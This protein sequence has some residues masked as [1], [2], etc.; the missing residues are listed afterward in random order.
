MLNDRDRLLESLKFSQIDSRR[1]NIKRHHAKTCQ[2]FLTH[3]DYISWLDPACLE[4]TYGFLWV[5]GKPGSG[6]S[7]IMKFA[8]SKMKSKLRP[9]D[10]NNKSVTASFFFNARGE[11]LEKSIFGMYRSLLYQLLKG[12]PELQVALDDLESQDD[13][14]SLNILKDLFHSAV[15]SL[16]QR[17]FTC[18]IDA[19]DE[20]DE[21]Q[22]REMVDYFED[23]AEECTT[24][25]IPF[26]ICF[27]SRHYPY[28]FIRRG[29]R[30]TLEDQAGH[31]KDLE[32]YITS[33]LLVKEQALVEEIYPRLLT[34]AAGV[35]M[36]V[37]LV[38]DILNK[39]YERGG[40]SLRKRLAEIPSDLSDLFK[41][42]LRRDKENMEV[43][44][45][46]IRW[47]LFA[48]RPLQPQEFYHA[49]WC[50]LAAKDLADDQ[51]PDVTSPESSKR[52]SIFVISSSKGLAEITSSNTPTV[53]FIHESV[54]D[55]LIKDRGIF[56][57]WPEL[58]AEWDDLA[59]NA[60]SDCCHRYIL[61]FGTRIPAQYINSVGL[62]SY[63]FLQYATQNVFC[64]SNSASLTVPQSK[65]LSIFPVGLWRELHN[66]F[67][68]FKIR[69]YSSTVTLLYILADNG[70]SN[71]VRTKIPDD[72][73]VE[74]QGERY[75]YPLF[76]ALAS[77]SKDTVAALLKMPSIIED[78]VDIAE[79]LGFRKDLKSYESRTPLTWA[80]QEGRLG[81]LKQLLKLGAN[82][83]TRDRK[84]RTPLSRA[85]GNGHQAVVK[86]LIES[87]ADTNFCAIGGWTSLMAASSNG[88]EE[89]VEILIENG[90]DV[91]ACEKVYYTPLMLAA[92]N[93]REA[94][95]KILIE[96]GADVNFR[97]IN[98]RSSLI[99]AASSGHE[100]VAK[101]LIK[102][103][104]DINIHDIDGR[105][106]LSLACHIGHDAIVRAL[107][108]SGADANIRDKDGGTPLISTCQKGHETIARI[109][110]Q[111]GA[112]V[113]A[114]D[115]IE[116]TSL[117]VASH[118]GHEAVAKLLIENG[119]EVNVCDKDGWTP[120]ILAC[121]QGHEAV[122]RILI[123]NGAIVNSR[124]HMGWTAVD[125]ASRNGHGNVRKLLVEM[126]SSAVV[127]FS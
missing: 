108:E 7:T 39:E 124:D 114:C 14:P 58:E 47:L 62:E 121:Q 17:H 102:N 16:G 66:R 90:A 21:Q 118:A 64:H 98:G 20:C 56:E 103:Q 41:D 61:G 122:A 93:D 46:C 52:I 42:I 73:Q 5:S 32:T 75:R 57:L 38:V 50:G 86:L 4:R 18:F 95:A 27:S 72:P 40:L 111:N 77:G 25:C 55:F 74:V 59:H 109:L 60:L 107:I 82:V 83:D 53:Q 101:L 13:C 49:L 123:H 117:E 2:W 22:V 33:R 63:P 116:W 71:L 34:K 48:N 35:F 100:A 89:V 36:W 113:N 110:I 29:V 28:I 84:D 23:L 43:L 106:P 87:G 26:R 81:I 69:H 115:K 3:P 19:L 45:L 54:R 85:A 112:D 68:R 125:W 37:V 24:Q 97:D 79:G 80:A 67:E 10:S 6:K 78:G 96:N 70:F 127:H 76:A 51:L 120:L 65:F 15:S 88:H 9:K 99:Q 1:L 30:L 105:T 44:L 126:E 11:Y 94:V 92:V 8:H 104:A 91:N 12:Y 119:A 31:A